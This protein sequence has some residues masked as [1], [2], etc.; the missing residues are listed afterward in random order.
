MN[1]LPEDDELPSGPSKSQRKRDST[2]LQ[3]LGQLLTQATAG[4][5]AKCE[6]PDKVLAAIEEYQALPDKHG[7]QRRQLQYIGKVMRLL[8]E[9]T[10]ERIHA[11]LNRNV[12]MDKRRFHRVEQ[13][14]DRLLASDTK[15]LADVLKEHPQL[16]AKVVSQL[17][18]QARKEQERGQPPGSSRKL[19]KLLRESLAS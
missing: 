10:I 13:L 8:D 3:D 7:A 1:D 15:V 16:N 19:F 2:A 17:V 9:E 12:E 14:R 18:R 6:L 4:V 5:L 11:Q